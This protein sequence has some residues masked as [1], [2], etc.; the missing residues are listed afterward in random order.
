MERWP[1]AHNVIEPTNFHGAGN[2]R[3]RGF[4]GWRLARGGDT[5][6][7]NG[8]RGGEGEIGMAML[9]RVSG[10][11]YGSEKSAILL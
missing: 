10:D 8:K 2:V 11:V 4:G 5:S 7:R 1:R 6:H 3:G 9:V